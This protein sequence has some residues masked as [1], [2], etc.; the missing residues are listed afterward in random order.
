MTKE[1]ILNLA[2][3]FARAMDSID[4]NDDILMAVQEIL[5]N[6]RCPNCLHKTH[7]SRCWGCY[8]SPGYDVT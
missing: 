5:H 1:E 6:E 4:D 2:R 8:D 3:Q 7:G